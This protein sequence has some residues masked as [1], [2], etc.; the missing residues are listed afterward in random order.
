MKWFQAGNDITFDI[1]LMAG[2]LPV[3]ADGG[4]VK[5]TV[6]DQTGATLPGLDQSVLAVP[7]TT[8]S[9]SVEAAGNTLA[10][11][12]DTESR[13]VTVA[14]KVAG[15]TRQQQASYGLY[16]FLPIEANEDA[17]RA[18]MG[19]SPEELPDEDI[20]IVPSYFHMRDQYGTDFTDAFTTGGPKRTAANRAL[21]AHAALNT[22]SSLQLRLVQ[23]KQV[24]NQQFSRWAT[25]DFAKLKID[26][27]ALVG[28]NIA[29][30]SDAL[31]KD[32]IAIPTFFVVSLP[33][34]P[35]TNA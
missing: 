17:V 14:F 9:I 32:L 16:P 25:V 3:Q 10:A 31:A 11:G 15:Q 8:A 26:L 4:T 18:M 22:L 27:T 21:A 19:V 13:F 1:E 28:S 2:G 33:I 29:L 30:L 24:E 23:S 20:E 7:G 6:R 35:V 12:S 34:D 5:Y